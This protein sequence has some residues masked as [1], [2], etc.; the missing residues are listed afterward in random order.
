MAATVN[1]RTDPSTNAARTVIGDKRLVTGTLVQP[2][3]KYVTGGFTVTAAELGFD[4]TI[5]DLIVRMDKE[6][7][8]IVTAERVSDSEWKIKFFSAVGTELASESETMKGKELPF[9]AMGE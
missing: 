1:K 2:T 6:A 3:A 5:S 9:Q 8:A 4:K 7:K